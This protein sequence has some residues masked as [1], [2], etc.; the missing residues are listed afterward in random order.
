MS[1]IFP[2]LPTLPE[3]GGAFEN[4]FTDNPFKIDGIGD[5]DTGTDGNDSFVSFGGLF[6]E[7]HGG[8]GDDLYMLYRGG[9]DSKIVDTSGQD[10]VV[11]TLEQG[12][13]YTMSAGIETMV[14]DSVWKGGLVE[15]IDYTDGKLGSAMAGETLGVTLHGNALNNEI[16]ASDLNDV[17]NANDGDDTVHGE[18]GNDTINGGAGKDS[19][20]GNAGNDLLNG[21]ADDDVLDG[22]TGADTM[23]GGTGDDVY[24]VDNAGDTVFEA[25]G[26]GID[27]VY[28]TLNA[29]DLGKFGAV[30]N[31]TFDDTITTGVTGTGNALAN[32]I[33]GANHN[34]TLSGGAGADTLSGNSGSD[35]LNGGAGNDLAKGGFDG[36][37]LF[38]DAGDDT[39]LGE[40]GFDL[41]RGGE[42][43]DSLVGGAGNDTL[44]GGLGKDVLVGGEGGL[45]D[46]TGSDVFRFYSAADSNASGYDT[47]LDFTKGAD[48]I[49]LASIDAST[50]LAGDQAFLFTGAG[51]L[52]K[53]AGDLWLEKVGIGT[54]VKADLQGDGVAD[55]T[56]M[57]TGV[58]D[59]AASDF[60]L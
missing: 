28:T 16:V 23:N 12:S 25:A 54:W 41:L 57:V 17:I 33:T 35:R 18:A 24:R 43:N 45:K 42:G 56:I 21:G 4:I 58:W 51:N 29:I 38:G 20:M 15:K 30:E 22:G 50:E 14:V 13:S 47:I 5:V 48:R 8:A 39:L 10:T 53:S 37:Q 34:D 59:L 36:D 2:K 3:I 1:G 31:L 52:F 55:L 19:L 27:R 60:V 32:Q 40:Q 11:A 49:H 6:S 7:M 26:Q 44:E 46:S 9:T